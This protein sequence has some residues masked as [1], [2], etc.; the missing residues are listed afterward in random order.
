[1]VPQSG[2]NT[3][4]LKKASYL[5]ITYAQPEN[6]HDEISVFYKLRNH[7]VVKKWINQLQLAQQQYKIDNPYRFY[8]IGNYQ[9]QIC[10]YQKELQ[11]CILIINSHDK[12]INRTFTWPLV[13]DDLN[14]LHHIF[15]VY[16]GLLDQQTHDFFVTA[17][18][19]TKKALANLNILVHKGESI[20]RGNKP[21]H[22][23]TYFG[24]PKNKVLSKNDYDLFT[25]DFKFGTVYL[26]YVE[27][28]KT[29]EDLAIDNDEYIEWSA[30]KPFRFY[31]ADFVV[32][33]YDQDDK[34]LRLK[35]ELCRQ[36]YDKHK[37]FFLKN[38]LPIDHHF[39][40][41][42]RIPL[43][44]I[45]SHGQDVLQLLE[46]RQYVKSVQII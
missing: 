14:Y 26:N 1:M 45:D 41:P 17:N 33:F 37:E 10:S 3:K 42:G 36:F 43:A 12:I 34:T 9:K 13:Q 44:D 20:L 30:F 6:G 15:E 32:M 29:L 19:E 40:K 7:P 25:D 24:S 5:K 18:S 23:V 28:G 31:S 46:T 38:K 39:L 21:R 35:R 16:H 4:T 22:V 27:I 2:S 8:G 11:Q